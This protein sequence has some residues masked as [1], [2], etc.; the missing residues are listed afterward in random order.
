MTM[1]GRIWCGVA[2]ELFGA[3][4][5]PQ[6]KENK[7]YLHQ[8]YTTCFVEFDSMKKLT[9]FQHYANKYIPYWNY[10][11]VVFIDTNNHEERERWKLHMTKRGDTL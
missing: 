9:E 8:M 5:V 10:D 2:K 3:N 4:I 7:Y 1:E 6:I 11:P